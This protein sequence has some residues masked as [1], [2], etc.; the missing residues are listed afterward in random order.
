ME[1]CLHFLWFVIIPEKELFT[2][3]NKS[4]KVKTHEKLN[5]I[6]LG[7]I[8]T[9]CRGSWQRKGRRW[10]GRRKSQGRNQGPS[11]ATSQIDEDID[12]WEGVTRMPTRTHKR[13]QRRGAEMGFRRR[14]RWRAVVE[15]RMFGKRGWIKRQAA[16]HDLA[17]PAVLDC[18]LP[19]RPESNA[20]WASYEMGHF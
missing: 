6:W 9:S 14:W 19:G 4:E 8:L 11:A 3:M 18:W 2:Y 10:R 13:S 1:T 12:D 7:L 15:E 20:L 17:S 16:V 5:T